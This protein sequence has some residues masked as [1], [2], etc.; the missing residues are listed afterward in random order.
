VRSCGR[1]PQST[2]VKAEYL[3]SLYGTLKQQAIN[4]GL[5]VS[6]V[7]SSWVEG[8]RIKGKLSVPGGDWCRTLPSDVGRV[9]VRLVIQTDARSRRS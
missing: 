7:S 3:M 6:E 5:R 8:P 9:D 1:L 2:S 4:T